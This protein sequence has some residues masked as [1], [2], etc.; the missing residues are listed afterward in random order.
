MCF[1]QFWLNTLETKTLVMQTWHVK[2]CY[3]NNFYTNLPDDKDIRRFYRFEPPGT[4]ISNKFDVVPPIPSL[5][6]AVLVKVL[7]WKAPSFLPKGA[8]KRPKMFFQKAPQFYSKPPQ[9]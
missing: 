5:R 2:R 8:K 3:T 9:F 4:P 6:L 1:D 7:N